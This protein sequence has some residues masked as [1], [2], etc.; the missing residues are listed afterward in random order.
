MFSWLPFFKVHC[1]W[2]FDCLRIMVSVVNHRFKTQVLEKLCFEVICVIFSL[3]LFLKIVIFLKGMYNFYERYMSCIMRKQDFCIC[4]IKEAD[5][6][7]LTAQ[8]IRIF[9]FTTI[10]VKSLFSNPKFQASS[11]FLWRYSLVCYGPGWNP[12]RLVFL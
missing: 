10:I 3:L 12:Q 8:L 5:E 6:L 4:E 1:G 2:R 11:L 7:F 9:V